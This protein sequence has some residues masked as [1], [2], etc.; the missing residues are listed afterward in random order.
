MSRESGMQSC[1]SIEVLVDYTAGRL[2]AHRAT[3]FERHT[4]TCR[5]C[6]ELARAQSSV[7]ANLDAWQPQ[8]VSAG[9]NRDLWRHID[10]D[11]AQESWTARLAGTLGLWKRIAPLAVALALVVTGYVW[12]HAPK[13]PQS[14]VASPLIVTASDADQ[15]ERTLADLQLLHEVNAAAAP[16]NQS[17]VY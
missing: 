8:P 9:F 10:A 16:A 15:L 17:G 14:A 1:P 2:D 5:H 12:D 7:W 3:A 13:A 6:A 4:A 11:L